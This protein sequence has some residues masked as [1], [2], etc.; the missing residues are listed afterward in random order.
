MQSSPQL[1]AACH[2]NNAG[3]ALLRH[4]FI[5]QA[6]PVLENAIRAI[7]DAAGG[8]C[9]DQLDQ[10]VD[11][12]DQMVALAHRY[13]VSRRVHVI[14][15]DDIALI[16]VPREEP[17]VFRINAPSEDKDVTLETATI[18]FN[19]S[20]ALKLCKKY[21]HS[22]FILKMAY[23]VLR[24]GKMFDDDDRT[25]EQCILYVIRRILFDLMGLAQQL[26]YQDD[27]VFFHHELLR[28]PVIYEWVACLH[29]GAA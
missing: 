19:F 22:Y 5:S 14:S 26:R 23:R 3:V 28:L 2:L 29:A 24:K 21:Q 18:L 1:R 25:D 10:N 17:A 11:Q 16:A 6:L 15:Q 4:G 20:F 7:K 12:A 8:L 13:P 9:C 27:Q